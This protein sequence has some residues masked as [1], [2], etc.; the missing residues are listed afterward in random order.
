MRLSLLN[1]HK[2]FLLPPLMGK[3]N[4][5]KL[6][7]RLK[8]SIDLNGAIFL[9]RFAQRK[10]EYNKVI[11]CHVKNEKNLIK[12]LKV[13]NFIA[14]LFISI[15][16]RKHLLITYKNV[17]ASQPLPRTTHQMLV[18]HYIILKCKRKRK[19]HFVKASITKNYV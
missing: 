16:A 4:F 2:Y 3:N 10:S 8:C 11:Y 7:F 9:L 14:F 13:F 19:S 15:T 12:T 18:F 1:F 17:F 5:V 6:I